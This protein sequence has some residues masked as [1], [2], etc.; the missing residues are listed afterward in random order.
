MKGRK[1]EELEK[2]TWGEQGGL[3]LGLWCKGSP[4]QGQGA[5]IETPEWAGGIEGK[6]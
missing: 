2:A 3:S 4:I 5:R 1:W 6:A